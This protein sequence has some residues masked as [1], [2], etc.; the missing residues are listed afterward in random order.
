MKRVGILVAWCLASVANADE[1]VLESGS[2]LVGIVRAEDK[3][4]VT[5]EVGAGT[6]SIPRAQIR[7]IR[8]GPCALTDYYERAELIA[9][10]KDPDAHFELG[11]WA[12][13]QGLSAVSRAQFRIVIDLDP[14]HAGARTALGYRFHEG[15]WLTDTEYRAAIGQVHFRGRWM[16]R[17]ERDAILERER[18][19]AEA[20]RAELERRE[21]EARLQRQRE[22]AARREAEKPRVSEPGIPIY[23]Y[24]PGYGYYY[25]FRGYWLPVTHSHRCHP[26]QPRPTLPWQRPRPRPDHRRP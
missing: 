8:R 17:E 14:N 13:N 15:R 21:E 19:E 25:W 10:S 23:V 9:A 3:D 20:K 2:T 22:E 16:A 24:F 5:I 4:W 12:K 18:K 1:I 6:V 7:E 11:L 26:W